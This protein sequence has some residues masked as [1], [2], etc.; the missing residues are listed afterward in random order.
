MEAY[1]IKYTA[2]PLKRGWYAIYKNW[3]PAIPNR[4]GVGYN[5]PT[6]R[7]KERLMRT[8]NPKKVIYSLTRQIPK[9]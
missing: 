2:K 1:T 3:I 4:P 6:K 5:H 7:H 8:K 9:K